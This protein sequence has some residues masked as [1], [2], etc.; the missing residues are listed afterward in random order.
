MCIRDRYNNDI[1]IVERVKITYI[2]RPRIISISLGY[3][4]ELA[5]H[6]HREI[7]ALAASSILEGTTNPRVQSHN[8]EE[9][10]R[11]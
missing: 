6:T 10:K 2:R 3:D 8:I 9:S 7:I 11:E 4:C 5:E 1:F